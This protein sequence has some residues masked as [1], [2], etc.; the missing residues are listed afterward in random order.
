MIARFVKGNS[1]K[2]MKKKRKDF[3]YFAMWDAEKLFC[4]SKQPKPQAEGNVSQLA[5]ESILC[6]AYLYFILI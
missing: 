6:F 1:I 5:S 4:P 2:I 3:T